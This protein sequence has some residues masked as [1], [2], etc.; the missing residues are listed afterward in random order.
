MMK[1]MTSR[2][3]ER[4]NRAHEAD[5]RRRSR[6]RKKVASNCRLSRNASESRDGQPRVHL[7]VTGLH[8]MPQKQP[9]SSPALPLGRSIFHL[10]TARQFRLFNFC[11]FLPSLSLPLL[12]FSFS[13]KGLRPRCLPV[14]MMSTCLAGPHWSG[15][16]S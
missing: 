12:L 6:P 1:L 2:D 5:R 16:L 11:V 8:P 9:M 3:S 13:P 4:L 15:I 7:P 14:G 10:L